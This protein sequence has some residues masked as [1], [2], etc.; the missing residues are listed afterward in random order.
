MAKTCSV[1][2]SPP[3]SATTRT[4]E[5]QKGDSTMPSK[6]SSTERNTSA[7]PETSTSTPQSAGPSQ[8]ASDASGAGLTSIPESENGISEW[9]GRLIKPVLLE[10]SSVIE[11]YILTELIPYLRKL[12]PGDLKVLLRKYALEVRFGSR[13]K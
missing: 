12:S 9:K 5:P 7:L 1:L 13:E 2:N 6:D 4:Q 3:P 11:L 8:T 10:T